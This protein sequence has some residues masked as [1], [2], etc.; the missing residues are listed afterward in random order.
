M[1]DDGTDTLRL[2]F[3]RYS[4]NSQHYYFDIDLKNQGLIAIFKAP[5]LFILSSAP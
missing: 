1:R 3:Y 2:E 4:C 5:R